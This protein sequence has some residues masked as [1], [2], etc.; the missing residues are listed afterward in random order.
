M[1]FKYVLKVLYSYKIPFRLF[2]HVQERKR[3][4]LSW[5]ALGLTRKDGCNCLKCVGHVFFAFNIC[6]LLSVV[7][8]VIAN[9]PH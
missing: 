8:T 2:T 9:Q 7:T 5:N 3:L 6:P 1:Y 4:D